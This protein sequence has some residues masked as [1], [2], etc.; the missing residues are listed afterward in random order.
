MRRFPRLAAGYARA[1]TSVRFGAGSEDRAQ[2][3]QT[4]VLAA[5]DHLESELGTNDYLVGERFTVADLTA[6]SLFYPLVL[7]AE[8]PRVDAR[9]ATLTRVRE[10][11]AERRGVGWIE[12]MFRRHRRRGASRT[13]ADRPVPTMAS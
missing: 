9:P 1:F 10:A 7:P 11:L 4:R 13:S 2:R 8:G 3:A 6:A 12:E 5:L